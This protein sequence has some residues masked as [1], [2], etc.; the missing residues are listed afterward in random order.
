MRF[1]EAGIAEL[2]DAVGIL[3]VIPNQNLFRLTNEK[4]T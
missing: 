3:L 2:I 1:A 4:T